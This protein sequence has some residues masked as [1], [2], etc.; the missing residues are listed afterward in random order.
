MPALIPDLSYAGLAVADGDTAITKFARMARGEI[1]GDA[2]AL[3]RDQLLAYCRLDTLGMVRLHDV[4][5]RM[6]S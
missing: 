4:L 1:S 6:A 5:S 3:T 2:V